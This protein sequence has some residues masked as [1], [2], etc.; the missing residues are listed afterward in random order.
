MPFHQITVYKIIIHDD[1]LMYSF[2]GTFYVQ[3]YDIEWGTRVHWFIDECDPLS[4]NDTNYFLN[5][6]V[7]RFNHFQVQVKGKG[8]ST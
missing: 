7:E 2:E 8:Q 1:Q 5:Y 4:E 3:W 6:F